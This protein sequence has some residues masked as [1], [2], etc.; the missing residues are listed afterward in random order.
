MKEF[1]DKSIQEEILKKSDK[2]ITVHSPYEHLAV[3]CNLNEFKELMET[4][5]NI[6]NKAQEEK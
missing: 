2:I 5:L 6:I 1:F 4:I 3:V